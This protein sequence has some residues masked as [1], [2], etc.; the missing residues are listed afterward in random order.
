[1][2]RIIRKRQQAAGR[3]KTPSRIPGDNTK[4]AVRV[5]RF[6]LAVAVYAACIPLLFIGAALKLISVRHAAEATLLIAGVNS[7]IYLVFRTRANERFRDPS[8][9]WL[10]VLCG[11]ALVMF[12]AFHFQADRGVALMICL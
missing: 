3:V 8:L 7:A 11:I 10:Q 5:R 1:M 9:T 2:Y 4:H 12:T 6:F